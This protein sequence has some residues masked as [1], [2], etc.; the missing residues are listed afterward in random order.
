[1]TKN[2]TTF[3]KEDHLLANYFPSVNMIYNPMKHF[4]A[5]FNLDDPQ[6]HNGDLLHPK[7]WY[8]SASLVL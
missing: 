8:L 1:M 7:G 4:N 3:T 5:S 6:I 2:I